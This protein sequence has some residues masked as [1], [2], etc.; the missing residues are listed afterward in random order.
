MKSRNAT[1][2][3]CVELYAAS[4]LNSSD[5]V[6]FPWG[7]LSFLVRRVISLANRDNLSPCLLFIIL[8]FVF[9]FLTL[10]A[11]VF[12][13]E[14]NSRSGGEHCCF[15]PGLTRNTHRPSPSHIKLI[16]GFS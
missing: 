9:P 8:L 4:L 7:S 13:T 1:N 6:I 12:C 14:L 3:P 5:I 15:T 2:V 16:V 11:K 10:L